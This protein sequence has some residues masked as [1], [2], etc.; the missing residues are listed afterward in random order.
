[1]GGEGKM[2]NMGGRAAQYDDTVC[3]AALRHLRSHFPL[4]RQEKKERKNKKGG[5]KTYESW[6]ARLLT[7]LHKFCI[8]LE[9]RRDEND[10]GIETLIRI[11]H[12][13]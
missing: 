3:V 4:C 10:L 2:E 6:Y 1:M 7:S 11:L 5:N 13:L 9:V 8:A 12:K